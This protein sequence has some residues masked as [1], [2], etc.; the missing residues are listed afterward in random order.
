MEAVAPIFSPANS[1]LP[2]LFGNIYLLEGARIFEKLIGSQLVKKFPAFY[3]TRLF[4]TNFTRARHV[5]LSG[6]RPKHFVPLH[7]ALE[8]SSQYYLSIHA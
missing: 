8:D 4:I 5:F 6:A 2:D 1:Q 7:A 3:G